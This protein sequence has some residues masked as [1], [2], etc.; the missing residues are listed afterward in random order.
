MYIEMLQELALLAALMAV[1]AAA[2]LQSD[3]TMVFDVIAG[4]TNGIYE[5]FP[6]QFETVA[7]LQG[8]E[9]SPDDSEELQTYVSI[10]SEAEQ[11]R[12]ALDGTQTLFVILQRL[13]PIRSCM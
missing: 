13:Q 4:C 1:S 12:E 9:K 7:K 3:E 8:V 6:L 5:L 2:R 11:L 10:N